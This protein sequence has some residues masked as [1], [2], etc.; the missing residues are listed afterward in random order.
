[1]AAGR[2]ERQ[3]SAS[4]SNADVVHMVCD[5]H[6]HVFGPDRFPYAE[7]R[8]FT[9]GY[10]GLDRL[11]EHLERIDAERVVLVQ[12]SVYGTDHRC[13]LDALAALGSRARGVSVLGASTTDSEIE[14]LD[15]AG[16]RAARLNLVVD[17]IADVALAR[18]EIARLTDRIPTGWH[19]Q[20]HIPLETL[21]ALEDLIAASPVHFVVDH[22]GLPRGLN[23]LQ[24][25]AW[26]ALLRLVHDGKA[27]VKLSA[28]YLSSSAP[29]F[30]DLAPL[31]SSLA[32]ANAAGLLW[33]S[34]W[35]HTQGTARKIG[36][37]TGEV[38]PF[39]TV[40]D[41]AWLRSCEQW[42][43]QAGAPAGAM[44][45]HAARLYGF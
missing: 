41:G 33:G 30:E 6:V 27:S 34:N 16:G 19:I 38:E 11:R 24:T 14:A 5:S 44:H 36:G 8:R 7:P 18:S 43:E 13:M 10:A 21:M 3:D 31:V 42:L 29:G 4:M 32:K 2:Q 40:D 20:L 17:G 25:P 35:P 26:S 45:H 12:P 28:P 9:P 39:R 15:Q 22:L 23:V 1:M 37:V